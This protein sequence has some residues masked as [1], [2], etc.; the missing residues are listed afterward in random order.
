MDT[1]GCFSFFPSK[2][3]GAA[4][5]AGMIVTNDEK[6]AHTL[7]CLRAHGARPKYYHKLIGGNFRL[8]ALQA[9]VIS[10]KLPH[11]DQWTRA[12]QVNAG[13]YDRLFRASGLRIADSSEYARNR[14]A[15]LHDGES[16]D[17]FLPAVVTDVHIF[18]Q[19]VIRVAQRDRLRAALERKGIGT[20]VYYPV[21]MHL[22]ECF[23]YLGYEAGAFPES[24]A[25]A[26]ETLA[27][28]IYPELTDLQAE[29]VVES[30]RQFFVAPD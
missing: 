22:Q 27:L 23:A 7:A 24:E 12:R 6:R 25:A 10:A 11:L 15:A 8:D 13:R 18:N 29:Y 3:L 5:D 16:V 4:G 9:A 19:Y 20:E 26:R 1:Y 17:V 28:P 21:P 30:I 14:F 2:N